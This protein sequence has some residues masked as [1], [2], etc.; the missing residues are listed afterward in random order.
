MGGWA[1]AEWAA[2]GAVGALVV[3]VVLGI[4][5]IAQIR[6]SR[7][8]RDLQTRPYVIV[9][10]EFRGR[11]VLLSVKNIGATPASNVSI[12]FDKEL[13]VPK[14]SQRELTFD[15]FER[16]IPLIAP[17]RAIQ[18]PFGQ[19]P[20]FFKDDA[21]FPLNYTVQAKYTDL[22]GKKRYPDPAFVLDLL[23]YKHAAMVTEPLAEINSSLKSI[24]SVLKG[25]SS[26]DGLKVSALDRRRHSRAL[27][28]TD[29][30]YDARRT[31]RSHGFSG[32]L[33]W[34]AQRWKRRLID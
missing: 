12:T 30:R 9:D 14:W 33:R 19:G 6:E 23:P 17:G 15:V 25:W 3:Y 24:Q 7:N 8:L 4:T 16:P 29:Y 2:F 10:F 31:F 28:R 13:H 20:D 32:V 11:S 18:I 26:F 27:D 1:A 21:D 5:A 22:T 34:Q